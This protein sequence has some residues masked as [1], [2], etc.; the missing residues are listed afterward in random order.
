[1]SSIFLRRVS[2]ISTFVIC[3][4]R[5]ICGGE[6]INLGGRRVY[7]KIDGKIINLIQFLK[8]STFF[9]TKSFHSFTAGTLYERWVEF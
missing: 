5:R 8:C 6:G 9:K 1:M 2:Y 4:N 3:I 7:V